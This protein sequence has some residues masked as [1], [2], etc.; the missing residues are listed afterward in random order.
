MQ[1]RPRELRYYVTTEN[2]QPYKDWEDGLDVITRGVIRVRLSRVEDGNLGNSHG[3]GEGVS[4][5]VIDV[6]PGYRVYF[7]Q[8]GNKV[9]LLTGGHKGTQADDIKTAKLYWKDY[10]DR[11]K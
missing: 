7:G 5:L 3:V 8:V 1:V 6:G 4:E 11:K 2:K 10:R 9:L